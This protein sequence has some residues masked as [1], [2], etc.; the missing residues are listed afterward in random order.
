MNGSNPI[1]STRPSL[2]QNDE[3]S[4][5][6]RRGF[7][8]VALVSAGVVSM[9]TLS[10]SLLSGCAH[11]R[12]QIP[13]TEITLVHWYHQYGEKGTEDAVLRYAAQYTK[14]HPKIGVAV[15]WVPG[16]YQTKLNTA[17]LT[18]GGPD[19]FE[20]Q[21]T[22]PMVSAGQVAPLD[23]LFAPGIRE[24]FLEGDL[25]VNAADGKIYGL[26]TINDTGVLY[27]RK[28]WMEKAAL[29]LPKTL[30]ELEEAAKKLTV[31][32]RKGLFIGNDGGAGALANILPWSAGEDFLV[33]DKIVFATPR[34][35]K[36]LEALRELNTS[37]SLLIGAP[38]DWWDPSAFTQG[39][40][41]MQWG[42]LWAFPV[43][44]DTLKEDFGT[45]AWPAFDEK[46]T[47]AT[48]AGGWSQMV[49][50]SSPFIEEAKAYIRWLWIENR[51]IQQDW[52]LSYGF[53]VPP[54]R[55]VA[56]SAKGLDDP[57]AAV[58]VEALAK[59]GRYLP[60]AWTASMNTALGDAIANIIK[61]SPGL[62]E[63]QAAKAKCERELQRLL[64]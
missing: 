43:I 31:K 57:R 17:L 26:K 45:M 52:S 15:V 30:A 60:P 27:F 18:A 46:G 47:P 12:P 41:A 13:G 4:R 16:D 14:A 55:S 29:G 64:R 7:L 23:D 1:M 56:A 62:P 51:A 35:A 22:L 40:C 53:H 61:G 34:A 21:L 25:K 10:A 28:S 6:T 63:L 24:D 9:G 33:D 11:P 32:G 49:N 48:F 8:R 50:A 3:L 5:L 58:A 37:G 2:P 54:R 42:G 38:T 39:L 59:Y 19:V 44:R 20:K 36:S